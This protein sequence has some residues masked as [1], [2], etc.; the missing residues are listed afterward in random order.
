MKRMKL[1]STSLI[2][3]VLNKAPSVPATPAPVAATPPPTIDNSA[4]VKKQR[5]LEEE[6]QKRAQ[7]LSATDNTGGAGVDISSE[8]VQKTEA[9]DNKTLLGQ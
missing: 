7:G 5:L 8:N 9:T 2:R 1:D 3:E 4:E 6:R